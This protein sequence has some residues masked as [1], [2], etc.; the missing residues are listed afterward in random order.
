MNKPYKWWGSGWLALLLILTLLPPRAE[1]AS[2][3]VNVRN[4]FESIGAQV[5]WLPNQQVIKIQRSTNQISLTVGSRIAYKNGKQ[6]SMDQPVRINS[7][8]NMAEMST[9]F[10]YELAKLERREMHYRVNSNDTLWKLSIRYGVSVD[11]L[12]AWNN[13]TTPSIYPGQHLHI[14]DPYYTV[15]AGDTLLTIRLKH[16]SCSFFTIACRS[17]IAD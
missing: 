12:M 2:G 17:H 8:T 10:V 5:E 3:M 6:I 15:Q 16:P 11:Q 4:V 14:S 13:L 9:R 1:A 7:T